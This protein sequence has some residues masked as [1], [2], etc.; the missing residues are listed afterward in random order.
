MYSSL[1]TE[2]S[3]YGKF[4]QVIHFL[5]QSKKIIMMHCKLTIEGGTEQPS[6]LPD[7]FFAVCNR[8]LCVSAIVNDV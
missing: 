2:I 1:Q 7:N 3:F 8:Q 4:S 5:Q 6:R